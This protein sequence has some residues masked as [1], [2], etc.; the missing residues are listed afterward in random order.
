M[1]IRVATLLSLITSLTTGCYTHVEAP[2]A[3]GIIADAQTGTPLRNARITR[4]RIEE[5]F[6]RGVIV[7]E[8]SPAVTVFS[9]KSG[10]FNLAPALHTQIAFMYLHNPKA[11]SGSFLITADGYT[12]NEVNGVATSHAHWRIDRGRALLKRE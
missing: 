6:V 8:G 10:Y 4:P 5:G 2:G 7:P 3:V 12:T 1:T 9:D 11:I